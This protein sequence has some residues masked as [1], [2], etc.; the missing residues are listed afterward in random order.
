MRFR[1]IPALCA[2]AGALAAGSAPFLAGVTAWPEIVTPAYFVSRG[3]L[4]YRE[5]FF[6]HTPLLIGATALAGKLL[7]FSAPVLR[8]LVALPLAVAAALVVLGAR[9]RR[10][11]AAIAA[12]LAGV[13]LLL[14]LV[15][16]AEGL[17]LWPEPA[18]AP[19]FLAAALC[20]ERFE[21]AG[22]RR[23]LAAGALLLGLAVLVK[24]TSAWAGLAAV[25]WVALAS[26]RRSPGAVVLTAGGLVLPY[27]LFV[28]AWGAAFRT[29]SHVRWTLFVPATTRHYVE[30]GVF[31]GASELH[32]ALAL[33]LPL[34]GFVLLQR[35]LPSRHRFRS[36][37]VWIALGAAGMAWP[38][39]GL[40]HLAGTTGI[41]AL[42]LVRS[43]LLLRAVLTRARRH[44]F[45][46]ARLVAFAVG[47][48]L[49]LSAAGVAILGGG[50][51][52]PWGGRVRYWDDAT[53][54]EAAKGV[55]ARVAPGGEVFVFVAPYETLYP[56]TRTR[57]PGGLYVNPAF[58]YYLNKE[59]LDERLVAILAARP[60]L[61]VLYR[62]PDAE[63]KELRRTALYRFLYERTEVVDRVDARTSWR[64]V[65]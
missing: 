15:V 51:L 3:L 63:E 17:A 8:L 46:P 60:G 30:I 41:G 33:F 38:R 13:P 1:A 59:G 14:L 5:I 44:R 35:S 34:A 48:A 58:W 19:L 52:L 16:Y 65:R 31:P 7:G 45:A 10:S 29:L 39:F 40:L 20:L 2:A 32:E 47:S 23:T 36:P 27:A 49:A 11:G 53:A 43:F 26:R 9:P 4:L 42:L 55:Q 61:P 62:E 64:R 18:L 6:P 37:A 50:P 28:L 57:F 12:L 24:Q 22:S 54:E 56:R 21:R 25:A